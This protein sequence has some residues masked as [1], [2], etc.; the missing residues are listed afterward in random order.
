MLLHWNGILKLKSVSVN[1]YLIH[2]K[3]LKLLFQ[4]GRGFFILT[5]KLL[6]CLHKSSF[7]LSLIIWSSDRNNSILLYFY[8]NILNTWNTFHFSEAITSTHDNFTSGSKFKL[9]LTGNK[10]FLLDSKLEEV[11]TKHNTSNSSLLTLL[12]PQENFYSWNPQ[13]NPQ[14]I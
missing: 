14:F 7:Y 10:D 5:G 1:T 4:R 8:I 3:D 13:Y 11:T 2:P 9:N 12:L 6:Q